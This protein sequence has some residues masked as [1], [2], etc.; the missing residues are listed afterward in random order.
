VVCHAAIR[1]LTV[2]LHKPRR[3]TGRRRYPTAPMMNEAALTH[4]THDGLSQQRILDYSRN[5]RSRPMSVPRRPTPQPTIHRNIDCEHGRAKHEL[6]VASQV[7][8]IQYRQ[9]VVGDKI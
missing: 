7:I 2:G 9:Q 1:F 8:G 5:V 6:D 3:R 4:M